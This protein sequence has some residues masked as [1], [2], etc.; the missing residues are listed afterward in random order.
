MANNSIN[1]IDQSKI[2]IITDNALNT[3]VEIGLPETTQ[4][5]LEQSTTDIVEVS[6]QQGPRGIAGQ[7][8]APGKL[9]HFED[10]VVT[11]SLFVSGA[12]DI[13]GSNVSLTGILTAG[14]ITSS[15]EGT[16]SFAIAA[17][18]ATTATTA[19]SA[20]HALTASF[21]LNVVE[22]TGFPFTG[23]AEITGSLNIVGI[24]SAS[25]GFT[26]SLEGT[27]SVASTSFSASI[28][29]D[30]TTDNQYI[31]TIPSSTDT[32]QQ[33]QRPSEPFIIRP[34]I[35]N[36]ISGI[37][38]YAS[39]LQIGLNNRAGSIS[40]ISNLIDGNP[41]YIKTLNQDLYIKVG[42]SG[43]RKLYISASD[44]I[45]ITGH[46]TGSIDSASTATSATSANT[47][48][49]ATNASKVYVDQGD[50]S[51]SAQ[52]IPYFVADAAVDGYKNLKSN[53]N[54]LSYYP[55]NANLIS[56]VATGDQGAADTLYIG[57]VANTAAAIRLQSTVNYPNY[58]LSNGGP[59][60]IT[61]SA[62]ITLHNSVTASSIISASGNIYGNSFYGDGSNLTGITA[63]E[64]FPFTGS[65]EITGSLNVIGAITSSHISAS[66]NI[67]ASFYYG[68][69]SNLTGTSGNPF[70]YTGEALVSG[71]IVA[72][73]SISASGNLTANNVTANLFYGDG[74]NLTG[75]GSNPFPHIGAARI[76]GSLLVSGSSV[77]TGSSTITGSLD[78]DGDVTASVI[79]ATDIKTTGT[80]IPKISSATN[81]IFEANDEIQ[82]DASF[83]SVSCDVSSSNFFVEN[84]VRATSAS[85][86]RLENETT[87][88]PSIFSDSNIVMTASNAVVINKVL[89]LTGT[90]T[91][92]I[93]SPSNGDMIYDSDQHKFFGY[94][95]GSW[96]AFH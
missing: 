91:G 1:I 41:N 32:V 54:P 46:I 44:G 56:G 23:S 14:G 72:T 88:V 63:T 51:T 90:T 19:T 84:K 87:G 52:I 37:E 61:S 2:V 85:F 39:E 8:G 64:P 53:I 93:T 92:S 74:S 75:I 95:N 9:E 40:L 29:Q 6:Q 77:I 58:I 38:N 27:A 20:S 18:T 36:N 70:P 45:E 57:G 50:T 17:A 48:T 12:G 10:L 4:V 28:A 67:S 42:S 96:I 86:D 80:G 94:A 78:V 35:T 43:Q 7:K 55:K 11:G 89:R 26:G 5:N 69:G 21:A 34:S 13:T 31:V 79:Q 83:V 60:H 81:I 49:N 47:A 15:L 62:G 59:L 68:D 3:S 33:L 76:T 73:G 66:G 71:S 24:V 82:I 30:V 25:E 16:S 22:G 65:A